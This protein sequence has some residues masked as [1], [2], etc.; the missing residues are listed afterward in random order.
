MPQKA[1][2]TSIYITGLA[3]MVVGLPLS[4]FV[5]S[6]SQ[7]IILGA[8]LMYGIENISAKELKPGILWPVKIF[9]D[10][11]RSFFKQKEA[12]VFTSIIAVHILGL[13]WTEDMAYGFRDIRIKLPMLLLP[14]I[15]STMPALN[16][17][18]FNG[19]LMV[20]LFALFAASAESIY[21]FYTKDIT[22][23]R[24][25]STHISHVRLALNIVLGI[26]IGIYLST[27]QKPGFRLWQRLSI[28]VVTLWFLLFLVMMKSPTGIIIFTITAL[29]LFIRYSLQQK[30]KLIRMGIP[31]VMAAGV[32]AGCIYIVNIVNQ[33]YTPVEDSSTETNITPYGG[34]YIH[35]TLQFPGFENGGYIGRYICPDEL[36]SAWSKRSSLDFNG[37]DEKGQELKV[38]LIRYLN[39]RGLRKDRAGI[40]ALKESDIKAIEGGVANQYYI[41]KMS[42]KGRLYQL[43]FGLDLYRRTGNPNGN[44]MLQRREYWNAGW[45]LFKQHMFIGT[46]TGD[47][48]ISFKEY[49]EA[50]N[51]RLLPEYR[52]RAH[53]QYLSVAIALGIPGLLIFII[54]L[55]YPP[56]ALKANA[57]WY[58]SVILIIALLSMLTEDTLETQAGATFTCFFYCLFLWGNRKPRN[59]DN[60]NA[61]P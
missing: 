44:S 7:F 51:S 2:S 34:I 57:N 1:V 46:G 19:I 3:L 5:M 11:F 6:V 13:L 32:I 60:K 40:E 58:F 53:N 30:K 31:V 56:R 38:T 59:V 35:D 50:T 9:E 22:D 45:Q 54:G 47:L 26:Y 23:I 43:F 20:Y 27:S 28:G 17:K 61:I 33:Y 25:I 8:W 10:R 18:Q 39:S 21:V 24:Q 55:L 16:K 12:L 29:V 49:Y 4:R 52:H 41:S 48:R 36:E 14:L 42:I 15:I 37:T